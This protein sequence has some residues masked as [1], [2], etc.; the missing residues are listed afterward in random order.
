MEYAQSS[1]KSSDSLFK[2]LDKKGTW[3]E[4]RTIFCEENWE[5]GRYK[6]DGPNTD[7]LGSAVA[8]DLDRRTPEVVRGTTFDAGQSSSVTLLNMTKIIH[9]LDQSSH[10]SA[11][12]TMNFR[13][14]RFRGQR[15]WWDGILKA[16][17]W[18]LHAQMQSMCFADGWVTRT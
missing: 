5:W 2:G 11:T 6:S 16:K 3:R 9:S 12:E 18:D 17:L 8:A 4:T 7:L 13:V 14:L 1:F 15:K 10:K